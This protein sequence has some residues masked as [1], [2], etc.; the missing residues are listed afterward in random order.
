[1][2]QGSKAVLSK[3]TEPQPS[4]ETSVGREAA[5]EKDP[6]RRVDELALC[7]F[8]GSLRITGNKVFFLILK[9]SEQIYQGL[10]IQT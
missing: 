8:D 1:M 4:T 9:K 5:P 3:L 7:T 6:D 10:V 2:Q